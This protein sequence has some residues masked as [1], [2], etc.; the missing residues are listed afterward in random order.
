MAKII[1]QFF[2]RKVNLS[3]GE[4]KLFNSFSN[5]RLMKNWIIFHS[6]K[7]SKHDKQR[8]GEIDFLFIVPNT[9]MLCLEVKSHKTISFDEN[10]WYY[11]KNKEKDKSPFFQVEHNMQSIRKYIKKRDSEL[12]K[13]L[14]HTAV[15]FTDW[16]MEKKS[17]EWD[18]IPVLNKEDYIECYSSS[19]AK[20]FIGILNKEHSK[21]QGIYDWYNKLECTPTGDQAKY[22]QNTLKPRYFPEIVHVDHVQV[23]KDEIK[24]WTENQC[25]ILESLEDNERNL[26]IGYAGTGKTYIGLKA[27]QD[28]TNQK[29]KT[30]FL[31]FNNNLSKWLEKTIDV[32]SDKQVLNKQ[33]ITQS[34]FNKL[35]SDFIPQI[36]Q[37]KKVKIEELIDEFLKA[38][39]NDEI[40]L[41]KYDYIVI[42]EVQDIMN[43][44]D[45]FSVLDLFIKGGFK[46]GNWLF[47]GDIQKQVLYGNKASAHE[48]SALDKEKITR[49]KKLTTSSYSTYK[50]KKNCRNQRRLAESFEA[51]SNLD[52]GYSSYLI[53][54]KSNENLIMKVYK[55]KQDQKH[56]INELIKE[57]KRK[58]KKKNIIL[59]SPIK[60][61]C[62]YSLSRK[63]PREFYF[64]G[65]RPERDKQGIAYTSIHAFKGLERAVVILTDFDKVKTTYDQALL[66][67][68]L[69]R[70]TMK[71]YLFCTSDVQKYIQKQVVEYLEKN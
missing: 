67:V 29:K 20:K 17:P 9:G 59:L 51:I 4:R 52:P 5:D 46:N 34:T 28:S 53:D 45:V 8:A 50:L 58:Y 62:A 56:Q 64:Y 63:Y 44:K 12:A 2:D 31:C 35:L 66:Y 14:L 1:P 23:N 36:E 19:F 37:S 47:L 42:D 38:Y 54:D 69:S 15:F 22:L 39:S 57:L 21:S 11:G 7:L 70:A 32:Y 55:N 6:L 48:T 30:L 25:E 65:K 10:H 49:I 24:R 71:V 16:T 61:S 40:K 13:I 3:P 26:I 43:Y 27:I 68:G 33:Y 60:K 41:E 18:D